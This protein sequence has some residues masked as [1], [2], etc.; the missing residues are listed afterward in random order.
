MITKT[1]WIGLTLS[2]LGFVSPAPI[3]AW[4]YPG[5]SL[6]QEFVY[7]KARATALARAATAVVPAQP[8]QLPE[9]ASNLPLI[10]LIG[11]GSL[12]VASGRMVFGK[13]YATVPAR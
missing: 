1:I 3:R 12:I 9:T 2:V 4:F 6:G 5:N 7:P 10:V 13:K 11:F 8:R